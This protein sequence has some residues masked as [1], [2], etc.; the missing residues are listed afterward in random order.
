MIGRVYVE[1][2]GR[3]RKWKVAVVLGVCG[4]RVTM[5]MTVDLESGVCILCRLLEEVK[6][7]NLHA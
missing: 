1:A 5:W 7:E 6:R 4:N 3:R 2:K